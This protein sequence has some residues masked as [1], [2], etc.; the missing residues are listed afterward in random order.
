MNKILLVEDDSSLGATLKENLELEGHEVT[1]LT[2]GENVASLVQ[3]N[4]YDLIVLDWMLPVTSGIEALEDIRKSSNIPV[5]MI[6]AKGTSQDRIEGLS[7]KADDYLAK[8]FHLKE[9]LLRVNAILRR[10]SRPQNHSSIGITKIGLATF[11]LNGFSVTTSEGTKEPLSPKEVG[12]LRML[13]QN[14]NKVLSRDEIL[15][16]VWGKSEFPSTRTIDNFIVRLRKLIE[17]DPTNPKYIIS[18]RGV[19]YSLHMENQK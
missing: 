17:K 19:G 12:I 14:E 1:W 13:L 15:N 7:L 2:S 5:I 6:S 11:D 10:V 18:H 9:F 16:L 4:I 8:P 3:K